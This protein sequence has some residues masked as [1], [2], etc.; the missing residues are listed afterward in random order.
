M[1][2]LPDDD[3][4]VPPLKVLRKRLNGVYQEDLG[5]S[6]PTRRYVL[7]VAL[8][9][10][11][12]S[13]PTLAVLTTGSSEISGG[14]RPGAMDVP[15]LPPPASGPVRPAPSAPSAPPKIADATEKDHSKRYAQSDRKL[16]ERKRPT[17]GSDAVSKPPKRAKRS[18][19]KAARPVRARA[20][21]RVVPKLPV[22]P[23][24]PVVPE[25]DDLARPDPP[26]GFPSLP[27]LPEVPSDQDEPGD[28]HPG[29]RRPCEDAPVPE[30]RHRRTTVH[31]PH[32]RRSAV[33]ERPHNVRAA[34]IIEQSYAGGGGNIRRSLVQPRTDEFRTTNRPYRGQHRAEHAQHA[35]ERHAWQRSSR[36]GRHH[37]DP[38]DDHSINHR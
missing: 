16:V 36:V 7:M 19:K 20:P 32:S 2:H 3:G 34:R 10:G 17:S 29:R 23:G 4:L 33:T 30:T 35:D 14:N 1:P 37:A 12:A 6:G 38:Y 25:D 28:P 5:F 9:V 15:F 27:N 26:A 31:I 22:V 13:V 8:L 21:R 11:L 24:L 18:E